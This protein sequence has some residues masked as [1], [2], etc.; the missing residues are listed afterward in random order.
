MDARADYTLWENVQMLAP[1]PKHGWRFKMTLLVEQVVRGEFEH[2]TIEVG[3]FRSLSEEQCNTLG[4]PY[5][6]NFGVGFTN[7]MALRIAFDGQHG[8]Y[9]N[10]LKMT[11]RIE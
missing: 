11:R 3:W 4:I 9:F 6:Q 2:Q 5:R 7:R 1:I 10:G 8:R